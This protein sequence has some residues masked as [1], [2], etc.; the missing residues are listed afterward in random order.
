MERV[1]ADTSVLISAVLSKKGDSFKFV[2]LLLQNRLE[3]YTNE[4]ILRFAEIRLII[5]FLKL[6]FSLKQ[7]VS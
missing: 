6:P 4:T 3:N 7:I 2:R 1:V 5:F